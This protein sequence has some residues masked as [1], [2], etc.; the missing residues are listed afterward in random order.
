MD[1]IK[2]NIPPG[3]S[4]AANTSA[5]LSELERRHF[6]RVLALALE[7]GTGL[8]S[9]G[10]SVSRVEIAVER[11][12]LSCGA[13]EVN[14]F[15]LPS[16]VLCSI[17]LGDGSEVS[18][19]KRNYDVSNNFRKMER[20]NQ[21]SRDFCAK[22][23]TASEAEA[24]VRALRG[25]KCCK[26]YMVV[27][28][29]ALLS[30]AF[31][32]FFGGGLADILPAAIVGGVMAWVNILLS[33]RDFNSY[34]GTFVTSFL[35]GIL[36]ILLSRLFIACGMSCSVSMIMIGTIMG[37][38][39]GLLICNA[40]RDMFS[41]DIYSGAFE[42][43][44][45]VLAILALAAGYGASLFLL[46]GVVEYIEPAVR[47]GAAY[48]A[49][50]VISCFFGACGVALLF[51]CAPKKIAVGAGNI[52]FTYVIYLL[53]MEFNGDIFTANFVAT[54]F[55]ATV[56]EALARVFKAPSTI[57]LVPA[58]IAFV[59]GGSL[60]YAMNGL[61]TGEMSAAVDYGKAAGLSLL[62]FSVAISFVSALFQLTHP[63][64]G[65]AA[66]KRFLR[67]KAQKQ[68]QNN[69]QGKD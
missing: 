41:G 34:A 50:S 12:C 4:V 55:A 14:V 63:L 1:I 58:I 30:G 23:I 64:K 37:V 10:A 13:E 43:L 56:A 35:G 25:D 3:Q 2:D 60:Y 39:P 44:N 33:R 19:M 47:V 22:K 7:I 65:K 69:I 5:A 24:Q 48:Y 49:Y 40:V 67:L 32:V 53:L 45:G 66:I 29:G 31:A 28:G 52:I 16:M 54:L 8:L 6:D 42:F 15:A 20:Y 17:K 51:N 57:F 46:R 36:S 9:C 61:V 62:G 68:N 38:V 11:V 59:P 27:T 18:Q 26:N 21:L